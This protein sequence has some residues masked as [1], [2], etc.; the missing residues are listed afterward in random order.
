MVKLMGESAANEDERDAEA[1]KLLARMLKAGVS[2]YDP[3]PLAALKERRRG[4]T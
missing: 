2:K 4:K 1:C 3:D